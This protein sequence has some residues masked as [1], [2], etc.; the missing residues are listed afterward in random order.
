MVAVVLLS[1]PTLIGGFTMPKIIPG[2]L[3][4]EN[5]KQSNC[6]DKIPPVTFQIAVAFENQHK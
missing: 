4:E 1:Y 2:S 5:G 6:N 3:A